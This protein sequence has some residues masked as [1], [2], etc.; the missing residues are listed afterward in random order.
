[1]DLKNTEAYE[2]KITEPNKSKKKVLKIIVAAASI[3]VAVFLIA[4]GSVALYYQSHFFPNTY[5]N[6]VDCSNLEAEEAA[7]LVEALIQNY[8]LEVRGR[9]NEKLEQGVLG[10]ITASDIDLQFVDTQTA[11]ETVLQQQNNMFWM[12]ILIGK[13]YGIS[14]MQGVSYD[15]EMLKAYVTKWDAFRKGTEP[16]DAYISD[17]SEEKNG[18]EIIAE[19][20]GTKLDIDGALESIQAAVLMQETELTLED[21]LYE[22]A[23]ITAEDKTLNERVNTINTWLSAEII[24]DWNGSKIVVDKELLRDWISF[25]DGEPRLDEEAVAEFV[26]EKAKEL[27]TYGKRRNFVTTQGAEITLPSGAYGWKTDKEGET[28]EL[29]QLIYEGGTVEK[30]PLYLSKGRQKGMND[31]G[32]SYVEADLTNQHLYLYYKGSLVLETDFVSG[33]MSDPGCITP[34]GVF[35]LTYKTTNAVLRGANYATPVSY[36]MPFHGNFGMHDATWRTE[37]G[38]DIY[39][40]NGSH[41]CINLPL[42][43]AEAIYGYISTGFPIICYY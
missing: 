41:G 25:V 24:Y 26:A 34:Y 6:G 37:F 42:D 28:E 29:I 2:E 7:P 32:S 9:F 19:T 18:Y 38:G 39:L 17:Y 35:G 15:E 13:R 5:I 30:E 11:I 36:W 31:I 43:K 27:D 10:D 20:Y 4:Y 16:K 3:L 33:I 23:N 22:T 1:M 21:S 14:L 8:R 40:T 12:E